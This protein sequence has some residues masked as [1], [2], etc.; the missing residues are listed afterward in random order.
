MPNWVENNVMISGDNDKLVEIEKLLASKNCVFDF[1]KVIPM[2]PHSDTFYRDGNLGPAESKKYGSN[3]WYDWS[4]NNWGTKWNSCESVITYKDEENLHYSFQTAWS[5]AI[6]VIKKLAEMFDVE[7]RFVYINEDYGN[8]CGRLIINNGKVIED[9]YYE[10]GGEK[11]IE[12]E[13]GA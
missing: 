12:E 13:F 7:I 2:P 5:P 10:T 6:P 3:N 1:D 4:V 8:D 9:T 11:M